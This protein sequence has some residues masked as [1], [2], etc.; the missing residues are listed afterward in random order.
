MCPV[1]APASFA[2]SSRGGLLKLRRMVRMGGSFSMCVSSV[3]EQ[4][5]VIREPPGRSIATGNRPKGQPSATTRDD[6][7]CNYDHH[8]TNDLGIGKIQEGTR[9]RRTVRPKHQGIV[10]TQSCKTNQGPRDE[11]PLGECECCREP[12]SQQRVWAPM[13]RAPRSLAQSRSLK[14]P[15][16][17]G[18]ECPP[19][20]APAPP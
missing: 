15:P 18:K 17:G 16:R 6:N 9:T 13:Q 14:G 20:F 5:P 8:D 7:G 1:C 4:C 19:E 10:D 11:R 12:I 2:T 3:S